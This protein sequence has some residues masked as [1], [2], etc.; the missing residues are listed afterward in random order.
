MPQEITIFI[1]F[2]VSMKVFN[3]I[4]SPNICHYSKFYDKRLSIS[5]Y[6]IYEMLSLVA[7][8]QFCTPD[9]MT[10]IQVSDNV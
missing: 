6:V 2:S 4:S 8:I 9:I 10:I 1:I 3:A 7:P 5:K